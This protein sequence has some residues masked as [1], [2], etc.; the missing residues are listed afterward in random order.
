[1]EIWGK[2][3]EFKN[4]EISS[5]GRVKTLN[6]K[7]ERFLKPAKDKDG[8]L[9]VVLHNNENIK[10]FR[11]HQ[12][13]AMAFLNHKLGN[14]FLHVDHIDGNIKNNSLENLRVTSARF[15]VNRSQQK[16]KVKYKG[17]MFEN[18]KYRARIYIDGIK[19]H[20]GYFTCEICAHLAY[21]NAVK[22]VEGI[23]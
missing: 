6:Y 20:L 13:V 12:L 14:K 19:K 15:N 2:I 16:C 8:Y 18:G 23:E 4:Y 22:K 17:V 9:K 3:D 21:L 10:T 1:M 11:V 5:L 7:K